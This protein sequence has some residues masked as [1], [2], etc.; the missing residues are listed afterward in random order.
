MLFEEPVFDGHHYL[1]DQGKWPDGHPWIIC[2][3]P[4]GSLG[5]GEYPLHYDDQREVYWCENCATSF[6]PYSPQGEWVTSSTARLPV[7]GEVRI[8]IRNKDGKIVRVTI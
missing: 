8:P 7:V 2:N 1:M 4:L 5:E 3:S 6:M